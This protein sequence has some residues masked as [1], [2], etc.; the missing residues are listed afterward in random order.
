MLGRHAEEDARWEAEEAKDEALRLTI[1]EETRLKAKKE[2]SLR[3]R[4]NATASIPRA[5]EE[6]WRPRN[7]QG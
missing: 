5:R 3:P 6:L 1:E 7:R 4:G 2:A